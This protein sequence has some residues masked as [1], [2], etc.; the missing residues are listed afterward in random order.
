M[1]PKRGRFADSA[2]PAP[3]LFLLEKARKL[4]LEAR[5]APA[6]INDLLS[7]ADPGRVRL[8]VDVE[9]QLVAL[10]APGGAGLV[11]LSLI[12]I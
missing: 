5:H 11:L 8:G 4:L 10:L 9:V 12:H 3:T 7:A 2:K 1:P 6:A